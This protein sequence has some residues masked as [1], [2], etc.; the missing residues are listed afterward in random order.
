MNVNIIAV[1]D[2]KSAIGILVIQIAGF[3]QVWQ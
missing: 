3:G 2:K 1:T